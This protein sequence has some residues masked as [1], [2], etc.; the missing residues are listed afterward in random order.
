MKI[1]NT[2]KDY[3]L[4]AN[5]YFQKDIVK[6]LEEYEYEDDDIV[7]AVQIEAIQESKF[8]PPEVARRCEG[9]TGTVETYWYEVDIGFYEIEIPDDFETV[10]EYDIALLCEESLLRITYNNISHSLVKSNNE[11]IFL[12][13]TDLD[14]NSGKSYFRELDQDEL[15]EIKELDAN[16][17]KSA[18]WLNNYTN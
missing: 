8:T 15:K 10:E 4:A 6:Y 7:S 1:L 12:R 9:T 2:L 11:K 13:S 17:V 14:D 16:D 5:N 18:L 3:K